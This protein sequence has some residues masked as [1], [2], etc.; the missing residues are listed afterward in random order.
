ML[1]LLA[2]GVHAQH[3]HELGARPERIGDRGSVRAGGRADAPIDLGHHHAPL[4]HV[5]ATVEDTQHCDG[6]LVRSPRTPDDDMLVAS[7]KFSCWLHVHDR[8]NSD[9]WELLRPMTKG[10]AYD[11]IPLCLM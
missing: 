7:H 3:A 8:S 10:V 11:K 1:G 6:L 4:G 2:L 9:S 5:R